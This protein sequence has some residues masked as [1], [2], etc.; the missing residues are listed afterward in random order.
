MST[1]SA[2]IPFRRRWNYSWRHSIQFLCP[3]LKRSHDC[4][5]D[6]TLYLCKHLIIH[7]VAKFDI[8][9]QSYIGV[10]AFSSRDLP[11]RLQ[12]LENRLSGSRLITLCFDDAPAFVAKHDAGPVFLEIERLVSDSQVCPGGPAAGVAFKDGGGEGEGKEG[13]ILVDG[14]DGV[15]DAGGGVRRVLGMGKTPELGGKSRGEDGGRTE[16]G[17]VWLGLDLG[18]TGRCWMGSENE[19]WKRQSRWQTTEGEEC[20]CPA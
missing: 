4:S 17:P 12:Y 16:E 9:I 14:G 3:F 1:A 19:W 2:S 18:L 11:P 7:N 13:G 20:R 6:L 8:Y 15:E 5:C 10:L